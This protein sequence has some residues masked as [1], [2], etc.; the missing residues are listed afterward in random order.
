MF[1]KIM[2]NSP[3]RVQF[4]TGTMYDLMCG[5]YEQGMNGQYMLNGG[6]GNFIQAFHGRGNTFKSTLMNSLVMGLIRS[7]DDVVCF[8]IDTENS[9]ERERVTHMREDMGGINVDGRY[10]LKSGPEWTVEKTWEFIKEVCNERKENIKALKIDTP[11]IGYGT[12]SAKTLLPTVIVIDSWSEM[13]SAK[14]RE[15][16][17]DKGFDDEKFR[18]LYMEEGNKKTL[19]AG[20]LNKYT[21]QYGVIVVCTARTGE[22]RSMDNKP[23]RKELTHQKQGDKLKDVG[24]K[25]TTLTHMLTSIESC[26][27]CLDNNKEPKFPRGITS[28]KDLQE[29]YVTGGRNKMNSSGLV[30]P[31]VV[32]Q[33]YGLLNNASNL[34]FLMMHGHRNDIPGLQVS[35][36]GTYNSSWYPELKFTRKTARDVMANDYKLARAIELVAR[37]QYIRLSWNL[38]GLPEAFL[39]TPEQVFDKLME[40]SIEMNDVLESTSIWQPGTPKKKKPLLGANGRT[41]MSLFDIVSK[42]K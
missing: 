41:Y 22:A 18:T 40:S 10:V 25:F 3:K 35:G 38:T 33:T 30:V 20:M 6:F 15:F 39:M 8:D 7:Y 13:Q 36:R 37:F 1:S 32:S 19:L 24:A 28:P 4:N 11:F 2:D 21:A 9:K 29:L 12:P 17:K 27:L 26:R 42:I 16:L 14:M 5:K 34:N 23:I 31:F